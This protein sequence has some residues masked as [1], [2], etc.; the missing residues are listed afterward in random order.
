MTQISFDCENINSV[1]LLLIL[2]EMLENEKNNDMWCIAQPENIEW[3]ISEIKD[4]RGRAYEQNPPN[5]AISPM[6]DSAASSVDR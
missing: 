1:Q 5:K 4:R 2:Y 6:L 3:L